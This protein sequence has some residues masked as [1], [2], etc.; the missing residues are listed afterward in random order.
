MTAGIGFAFKYT[1]REPMRIFLRQACLDVLIPHPVASEHLWL[2]KAPQWIHSV[3]DVSD[4]RLP[5]TIVESP[6]RHR[7]VPF[8]NISSLRSR[9]IKCR[10]WKHKL[11][12]YGVVFAHLATGYGIKAKD[13]S[14]LDSDRWIP[15]SRCCE[16][17]RSESSPE[18]SFA[19]LVPKLT[20]HTRVHTHAHFGFAHRQQPLRWLQPFLKHRYVLSHAK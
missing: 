3:P 19:I 15:H 18:G 12:Y 10:Q 16:N 13:P 6:W 9:S 14:G 5:C 1:T 11:D 2:V 17:H 4:R 20:S 7:H 8:V